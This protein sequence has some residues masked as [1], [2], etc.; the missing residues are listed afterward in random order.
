MVSALAIWMNGERVGT[1]TVRGSTHTL[2]YE[3]SW[4]D[5]PH[6][7]SLSLS[8]AMG[9][10]RTVTGPV[11]KHYFDNLLPDNAAIRERLRGRFRASSVQA[12]ELLTA[13][14]RDCVGAV[15]LL[16]ESAAAPNVKRLDHEALDEAQVA[17]HLDDMLSGA[18]MGRG[19]DADDSFRISI[20]G[21]QEKAALLRIGDRW[22]LPRGSTP[23]T[24]ILKLPL[25]LVGGM[26]ANMHDSVEN[27]W[28]CL[29]LLG[30]M[31]LPT[32]DCEMARF[33]THKVLVVERFDR[34]WMDNGTWIARI[35]QEDFC[36][37]A[38]LPSSA[39]YEADGGPGIA[40]GLSLLSGSADA[41]YDRSIFLLA[42]LA[43]WMLAAIDGH[44]K[45]FSLFIEAGDAYRMTPLYD[46]L[47]AWPIE[48]PRHH[49][50]RRQRMKLAMAVR[51]HNAHYR[52]DEIQAR[53][54]RQLDAQHRLGLGETML[55]LA[56]SVPHA[57]ARTQQQLPARFPEAVWDKVTRQL[58]AQSKRFLRGYDAAE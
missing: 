9:A 24:H 50:I 47:S 6:R 13:I 25:G 17:R 53:H 45:N 29:K 14:G 36:Q 28:L 30:A 18:P 21:A 58:L 19:E 22:C 3:P 44:A 5:A 57:I 43:F 8:L 48:G 7:R 10:S 2:Q 16:P 4:L 49:Q 12:F 35:P 56:R 31:G 1:W 40:Q 42:Q 11:V 51:A 27:E 46:V 15:Q 26:Q 39:K 20:A 52:L 34:Q 55:T 54:W 38:G 23:T 37:A 32:V 41:A 33:G